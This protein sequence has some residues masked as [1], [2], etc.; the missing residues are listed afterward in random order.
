MTN[1]KA[2]VGQTVLPNSS[3]NPECFQRDFLSKSELGAG[4][5]PSTWLPPG[6]LVEH[7]Y[8]PR[9][10]VTN[11]ETENTYNTNKNNKRHGKQPPN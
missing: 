3:V 1:P 11:N 2:D 9:D 6:K 5:K 10:A 4:G 7:N 8:H